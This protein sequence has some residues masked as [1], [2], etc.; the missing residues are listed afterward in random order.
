MKHVKQKNG[1]GSCG[2]VAY[3]SILGLTELDAIRE[4]WGEFR[5]DQGTCTWEVE[6]ALLKRNIR[7]HKLSFNSKIKEAWWL[8]ALSHHFPLYVA[9]PS[10]AVAIAK[11]MVYD[12]HNQGPVPLEE[13]SERKLE[14]LLVVDMELEGFSGNVALDG[15]GERWNW[16]EE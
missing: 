11:G 16:G 1:L 7:T 4:V 5:P 13:Y 14:H 12:G 15:T 8:K 3:A 9:L 2:C 6:Q 10:H